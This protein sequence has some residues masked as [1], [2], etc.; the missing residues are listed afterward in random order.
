MLLYKGF[1]NKFA[2]EKN[3]FGEQHPLK[4]NGEQADLRVKL[5][6]ILKILKVQCKG[7][8]GIYSVGCRCG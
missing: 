8:S 1:C 2:P 7:F 5:A 6:V 3:W 4:K